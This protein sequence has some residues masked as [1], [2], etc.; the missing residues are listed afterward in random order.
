M[1][2]DTEPIEGVNFEFENNDLAELLIEAGYGTLRVAITDI[3]VG[4]LRA[5]VN[6]QVK[7]VKSVAKALVAGAGKKR[8]TSHS[9]SK[10]TDGVPLPRL[11]ANG[12]IR[13]T[14]AQVG[15]A[16]DRVKV[17]LEEFLK[18]E[19][20]DVIKTDDINAS[21]I[22][23][24]YF[25][26]RPPF[27]PGRKKDEFPDAIAIEA[28]KDFA[29]AASPDLEI[30]VI[31][32]DGDWFNSLHGRSDLTF[33]SRVADA[34]QYIRKL[35]NVADALEALLVKK[36]THLN[37]L[38]SDEFPGLEFSLEDDWNADVADVEV[39]ASNITDVTV[40][41][42]VNRRATVNF[43]YEVHFTADVTYTDHEF[44]VWDSEEGDYGFQSIESAKLETRMRLQG[45]VQVVISKGMNDL[46]EVEELSLSPGAISLSFETAEKVTQRH[47]DTDGPEH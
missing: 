44:S 24:N 9:A 43:R 12:A 46:E 41:A 47:E 37:E 5:H 36:E 17:S 2:L 34:L 31:S 11:L 14:L 3:Q 25:A 8:V 27:G 15:Q 18:E 6:E 28:I 1:I 22:V 16:A 45:S 38:I 32:G 40:I 33:H 30:H 35:E 29:A 42:S 20:L 13:Q 39:L 4:E 26:G 7:E 21:R 19:F 23:P 10:E